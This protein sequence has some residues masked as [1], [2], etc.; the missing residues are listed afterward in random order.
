MKIPS[1]FEDLY[2]NNGYNMVW[3][4]GVRTSSMKRGIEFVE[5]LFP[6]NRHLHT[7]PR[8]YNSTCLSEDNYPLAPSRQSIIASQFKV[9]SYKSLMSRR[10]W[11]LP[12]IKPMPNDFG[13]SDSS[14][15][16]VF[17]SRNVVNPSRLPISSRLIISDGVNYQQAMLATQL[18]PMANEGQIANRCVVRVDECVCNV[19]QNK[20]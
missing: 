12:N 13:K 2:Q 17:P 6:S 14:D 16:M 9:P 3:C 11:V 18:N 4:S 8:T 5:F 15:T 19:V 7:T 20:R 10:F 1:L